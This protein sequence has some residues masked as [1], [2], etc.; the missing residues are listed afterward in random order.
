MID[1]KII[2][3]LY[4]GAVSVTKD[5]SNPYAN[6][7]NPYSVIYE[8]RH[9]EGLVQEKDI[10]TMAD[11][12]CGS[13]NMLRLGNSN[14]MR[15]VEYTGY[16]LNPNFV[17]Y[18]SARYPNHKFYEYDISSKDLKENYDLILIYEV[19]SYFNDEEILDMID[20][21]YTKC[22]K[23]LSFVLLD[24][25]EYDPALNIEQVSCDNLVKVLKE[26]YSKFVMDYDT[27]NCKACIDIYKEEKE[28]E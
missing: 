23:V 8:A 25:G 15:D 19:L 11:L 4:D 24:K 6:L 14:I 28:E 2:L 20:Y 27:K 26:K 1:K 13:G 9:M 17:T 16:D 18:C 5:F 21:Y 10:K 22:N 7:M 3:D 12:G